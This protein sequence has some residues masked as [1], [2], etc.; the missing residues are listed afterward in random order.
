MGAVFAAKAAEWL[1]VLAAAGSR[2]QARQQ[3]ARAG[4]C[5]A[6][7]VE[8]NLFSR[9]FRVIRSYGNSF[10]ASLAFKPVLLLHEL[11]QCV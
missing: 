4:S 8:A 3:V 9:F 1:A 2:L 11:A 5:R 7:R 10:G 6:V